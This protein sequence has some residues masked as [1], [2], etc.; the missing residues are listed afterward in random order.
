MHAKPASVLSAFLI[1]TDAKVDVM[2]CA[3]IHFAL[4]VEALRRS[5]HAE[6]LLSEAT[7]Q[8]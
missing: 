4:I 2:F 1:G 7:S 6:Q 8:R 5:D 3:F